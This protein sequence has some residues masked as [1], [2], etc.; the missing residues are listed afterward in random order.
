MVSSSVPVPRHLLER[1]PPGAR[2]VDAATSRATF[3][4]ADGKPSAGPVTERVANPCAAGAAPDW[5]ELEYSVDAELEARIREILTRD[6]SGLGIALVMD[7][8]TGQLLAYVADD[9]ERLPADRAYPM[10]SL[11]K[12]VTAAALLRQVPEASG[13]RCRFAGSPWELRAGQLEP[14]AAGGRWQ[15]FRQA[16]AISNNQCFARLAV[17]ELGEARLREE[18]RR[19]GLLEAPAWG[20]PP[21]RLASAATPLALGELGS[22][23]SGS[24]LSPLA[25]VQL[26]ATLAR[27]ERVM[28]RWLTRVRDARGAWLALPE[29]PT[30]RQVWSPALARRLREAL[31]EVTRRGTAARGFRGPHGAAR[32]AGV[33]VAGTTGSLRGEQPPGLY[34]WFIGVAPAEA[35]RVALAVLRVSEGRGGGSASAQAAAILQALFCR[36]G[37]C[38]GAHVEVQLAR[39]AKHN[40]QLATEWRHEQA[41]AQAGAARADARRRALLEA[42]ELDRIPQPVGGSKLELPHDLRRQ[43]AEGEIVLLVELDP[44]GQVLAVEIESSELPGF[45]RLVA[46]Q[47][48]AWSFTP[49]TLHGRPVHARARLPIAIR[50]R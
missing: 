6:A 37:S 48:R 23:L 46:S 8:A 15:S 38:A 30:P 2:A 1:L 41:R 36:G 3:A 20:H 26:A 7:P 33:E 44:A 31:V 39:R 35:P 50:V 10:A 22:G 16:L 49:P 24:H 19:L 32:L 29:P 42:A 43:Q 27:G 5:F 17:H 40:E 34:Q 11:V 4:R 9:P 21:G 12:V 45:E 25:A 28:P 47:V 13:W 18:A 14:P